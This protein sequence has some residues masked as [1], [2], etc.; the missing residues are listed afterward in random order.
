[1]LAKRAKSHATCQN[2]WLGA[3]FNNA[4]RKFEWID[5]QHVPSFYRIIDK[6]RVLNKLFDTIFILRI[7]ATSSRKKSSVEAE[8]KR[9][10]LDRKT[11]H[12]V[13]YFI[14]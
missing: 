11:F 10:V 2:Y 13:Y 6:S 7:P 4:S 3:K 14:C 5:G 12:W 8:S 9:L 1:M